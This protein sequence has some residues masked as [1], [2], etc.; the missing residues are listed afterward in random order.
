MF[1]PCV[2]VGWW[3]VCVWGGGGG[4]GGGGGLVRDYTYILAIQYNAMLLDRRNS[5]HTNIMCILPFPLG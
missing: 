4:G 1:Y 2:H 5:A 3:C